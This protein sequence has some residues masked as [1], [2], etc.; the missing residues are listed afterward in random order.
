MATSKKKLGHKDI[1][2]E[3]ITYVDKK[4]MKGGSRPTSKNKKKKKA[5]P[6][7]KGKK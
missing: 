7:K 1:G 4:G 3:P 2:Q 5:S 6:K